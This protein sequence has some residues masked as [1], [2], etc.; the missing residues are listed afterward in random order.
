MR[1]PKVLVQSWSVEAR[2]K[3]NKHEGSKKLN[4]CFISMYIT[5]HNTNMIPLYYDD[6]SD[7]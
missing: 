5:K 4:Y 3:L 1:H 7:T 6:A 2:E